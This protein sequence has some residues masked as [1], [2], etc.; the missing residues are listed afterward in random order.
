MSDTPIFHQ[1]LS[2]GEW[3]KPL[4]QDV[5]TPDHAAKLKSY[6]ED[7]EASGRDEGE[8]MPPVKKQTRKK[9]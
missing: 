4:P 1:V 7:L 3:R 5:Q 2:A 6:Y 9:K 8:A